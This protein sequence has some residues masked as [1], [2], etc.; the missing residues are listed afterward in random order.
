MAASHMQ[1]YWGYVLKVLPADETLLELVDEYLIMRINKNPQLSMAEWTA[2]ID[3]V[4]VA[5]NLKNPTAT[6]NRIRLK[7]QQ[8]TASIPDLRYMF[9][10]A[11]RQKWN[12]VYTLK[13]TDNISYYPDPYWR[14]MLADAETRKKW[15]ER[16]SNGKHVK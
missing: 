9:M 8:V 10:R 15:E 7:T 2:C 11:T 13:E 3:E 5:Y 4:V 1:P 14:E 16:I 6:N 12:H